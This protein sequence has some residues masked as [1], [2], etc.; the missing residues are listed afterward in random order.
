MTTPT[1]EQQVYYDLIID[2]WPYLKNRFTADQV[3]EEMVQVCNELL[4]NIASCTKVVK[5]LVDLYK[6]FYS[7]TRPDG[8]VAILLG[9]AKTVHN[10]LHKVKNSRNLG[11]TACVN[12]AMS[13]Y[14]HKIVEIIELLGA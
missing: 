9:S 1:Q 13:R 14:H 6:G 8:W 11:V 12:N 3:T 2:F 7:V 5:P 4:S 10:W